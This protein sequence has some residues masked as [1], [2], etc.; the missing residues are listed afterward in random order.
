MTCAIKMGSGS[1][2][3]MQSSMKI[4]TGSQAILRFCLRNFKGSNI[5]ITDGSDI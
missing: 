1:M 5:S 4:G 2:I 3:Y